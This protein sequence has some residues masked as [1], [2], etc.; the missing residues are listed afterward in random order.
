MNKVWPT[1]G[2]LKI[3]LIK[4]LRGESGISLKESKD[5]IE[6][7]W[8]GYPLAQMLLN[9]GNKT[10]A[11]MIRKYTRLTEQAWFEFE[12]VQKTKLGKLIYV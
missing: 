9:H 12:G 7:A 6:D 5:I 4:D 2:S 10:T 3:K 1:S 11:G 8:N